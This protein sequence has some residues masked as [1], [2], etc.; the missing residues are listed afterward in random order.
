[1]DPSN[2]NLDVLIREKNFLVCTG[3]RVGVG[4]TSLSDEIKSPEDGILMGSFGVM[5]LHPARVFF[6]FGKKGWDDWLIKLLF[7]LDSVTT[8]PSVGRRRETHGCDYQ[9]RKTHGVA[10]N[11]YLRKMLEKPKSGS[12]N[13]KYERFG[14]LFYTR[15]RY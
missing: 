13:F 2:G 3:G 15:G 14:S 7:L 5:D 6:F 12:M 4:V 10:T 1:M 11:V 8:Y 9:G